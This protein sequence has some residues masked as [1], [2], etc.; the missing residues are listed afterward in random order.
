MEPHRNLRLLLDPK[1]PCRLF[2]PVTISKPRTVDT[3]NQS[4]FQETH[5]NHGQPGDPWDHHVIHH[6]PSDGTGGFFWQ[7]Q[8]ISGHGA[9]FKGGEMGNIYHQVFGKVHSAFHPVRIN[10]SFES[11]FLQFSEMIQ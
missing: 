4:T 3:V 5:Q 1:P 2:C 10:I 11:A 6:S 7:L 8:L 9:M